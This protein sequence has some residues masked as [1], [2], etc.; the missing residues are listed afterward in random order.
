MEGPSSPGGT[1]KE[2]SETKASGAIYETTAL[3]QVSQTLHFYRS[4]VG[5][6]RRATTRRNYGGT[7]PSF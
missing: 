1:P 2:S 5:L 3:T 4:E 7:P 6:H